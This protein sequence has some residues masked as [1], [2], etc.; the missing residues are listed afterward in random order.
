M[1]NKNH[2]PDVLT[3]LANLSSDEVFTPPALANEMLD[4]LP[5]S[6]WRDKNA[7]FLDPFCKSGV[8]LREITKRLVEGLKKEIPDEQKRV[9]H[10]LKN[11]VFG[12]AITEL[13]AL[14]SRRS[15]YC[16]KS[17]N[18][19]YSIC[20]SFDDL[21]GN[22]VYEKIKH[23]WKDGHCVF[24]GAS[25]EANDRDDS[26]EAHAYQFIHTNNPEKLFPMKF[27]VI[28]GNPPYQMSDGGFGRSASPI[29]H[30]FVKQAKKL[31]PRYLAMIIPSRWFSGGKGLDE[32]RSNMLNDKRLRKIFDFENS[33]DVFPG[34]DVAGGICYF[35]WERDNPGECEIV[36]MSGD[37]PVASTRPL[38]EF[39]FFVRNG[40]AVKLIRRI[41]SKSA[42]KR[43]LSEKVSSRNPFGIPTN[44]AP[45][46]QGTPCW[47]IQRIGLKFAKNK[48]VYDEGKILDKWKLLIPKAP[49]AG[50]TDFSK[51]VGFYYDGNT[52]IAKPGECC[53]DS[54]LVACA[55]ETK[56]EVLA[57]KSYLF[58]KTVRYLLLQ[59]VVS[60]DVTRK[61]Y[62][63]IPDL[64]KYEG[65]YTDTR[66]RKLWSITDEEWQDIDARISAIKENE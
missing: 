24:C 35:L 51:P 44:Y 30:E 8:F 46:D 63:F 62:C 20:D 33:S 28:I 34:V 27:D 58:T 17:A 45:S 47:F 1:S 40:S 18:S 3:C 31:S 64:E 10:I 55:F 29:Y 54:W 59:T 41:V 61:N 42:T 37:K 65:E 15:L 48:D 9:N 57:F 32:F 4:L 5:K 21:S 39:A 52:R 66:L 50:Q 13:T 25:K 43:F 60:Q 26:L 56:A 11:Q 12:I 53:T 19:E 6:I 22:V 7:K 49:I 23:S 36:N 14:L 2:N 16:S 38:N